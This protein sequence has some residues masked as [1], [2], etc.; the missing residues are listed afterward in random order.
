MMYKQIDCPQCGNPTTAKAIPETQ[1][2]MWCR[3]LFK[4]DVTRRNKEGKKAKYDWA[5]EPVDFPA[6]TK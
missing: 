3:R 1:K 4:V 2:C 6:E 5:A